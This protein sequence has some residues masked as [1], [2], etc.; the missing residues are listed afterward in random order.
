MVSS[1]FVHYIFLK[2]VGMCEQKITHFQ[3]SFGICLF[4]KKNGVKRRTMKC[5]SLGT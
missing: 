1:L 3:L 5:G 2:R 4:V